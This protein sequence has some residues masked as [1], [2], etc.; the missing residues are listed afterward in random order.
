MTKTRRHAAS[1]INLGLNW[2]ANGM[3]DPG[4]PTTQLRSHYRVF[5][6]TPRP[7]TCLLLHDCADRI[8]SCSWLGSLDGREA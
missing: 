5:L 8:A 7:V 6:A 4:W 1:R 3:G 2:R